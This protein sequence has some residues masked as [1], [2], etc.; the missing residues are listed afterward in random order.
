M[1]V[2]DKR[3]V[4]FFA[5]FFTQINIKKSLLLVMYIDTVLLKKQLNVDE[6]FIDDDE[7]IKALCL[8]AESA[9]ENHIARPLSEITDTNGNL[10]PSV[11]HAIMMM[12]A[13]WYANRESIAFAQSHKVELGFEYLLQPY[14][15]YKF[16]TSFGL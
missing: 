7:Y 1:S 12:V 8:A 2:L 11:N 9:V 5:H 4:F 15:S 6:S 16:N 14:K 13:H 3:R 10:P